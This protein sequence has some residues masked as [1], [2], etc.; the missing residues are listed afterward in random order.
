MKYIIPKLTLIL[1]ILCL[2]LCTASCGVAERHADLANK[3]L[4][5]ADYVSFVENLQV[6]DADLASGVASALAKTIYFANA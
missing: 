6:E 2:V 3:A 5:E 4:Q 1:C